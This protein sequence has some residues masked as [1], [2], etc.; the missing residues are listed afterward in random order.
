M[1]EIKMKKFANQPA[2]KTPRKRK[3]TTPTKDGG[4]ADKSQLQEKIKQQ[5]EL[6]RD[7]LADKQDLSVH[8]ILSAPDIE[9]L[10]TKKPRTLG[11]IPTLLFTFTFTLRSPLL[12]SFATFRPAD[13]LRWNEDE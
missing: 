6:L 1:K 11:S 3:A 7:E 13:C 12:S 10:S 2:T 4:V 9:A 8:H 5:L